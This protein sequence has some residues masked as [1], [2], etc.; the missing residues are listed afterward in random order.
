MSF[1]KGSDTEINKM[2]KYMKV[3]LKY[4]ENYNFTHQQD[5][6]REDSLEKERLIN[7][8]TGISLVA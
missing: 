6:E 5:E 2:T 8:K 4:L 3:Q 1:K 7:F